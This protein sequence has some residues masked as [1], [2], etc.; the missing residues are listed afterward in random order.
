MAITREDV[1][2]GGGMTRGPGRL[3]A[4]LVI[5]G[6]VFASEDLVLEGQLTGLLQAPEHAITVAPGAGVRG[7]VFARVILVEGTVQG[8]LTAT[9]LIEI[10]EGA[11]VDADLSAPS[12]AIAHGAQVNG[13]IDMRRTEAAARVARYRLERTADGRKADQA[14]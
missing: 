7:R 14:S 5:E 8:S 11:K 3:A 6:E 4:G 9:G 2:T 12:I 13:K 10:G 1:R